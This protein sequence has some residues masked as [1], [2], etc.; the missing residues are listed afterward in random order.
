MNEIVHYNGGLSIGAAVTISDVEAKL[1]SVSSICQK[2]QTRVFEQVLNMFHWFA[3]KQIRNCATLGG[4]LSEFKKALRQSHDM[5]GMV[6]YLILQLCL[7]GNLMTGSPISDLSPVLMASGAEL[8]I[9]SSSE[10]EGKWVKFDRTFFT[11]YRKNK[12]K[13]DEVIGS[14]WIPYTTA[15]EYVVAYKQ[16]RRREDDIAIVNGA[17]F[18]EI[19]TQVHK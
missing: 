9:L 6:G 8:Q 1:K 10:P 17:F 5:H 11:G 13:P 18:I 12:L 15:N 2:E 16:S 19:S 7:L 3:G 4:N 14:V